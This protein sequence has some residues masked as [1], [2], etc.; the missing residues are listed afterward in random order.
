MNIAEYSIKYKVI[1]GLFLV[2]LTLGGISAF[3][4]LGRLE[5]P[6]FTLKDALIIATYPGA[7][8]QEV[9]EEL[10]YPLEREIRQ[11]PYI[12]NITSISSRGMSQL[13]S[14]IHI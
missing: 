10:T 13:L 12:D 2:L 8:P 6:A 4:G 5:D 1:S 7:T 3:N 11:L 14:L 9:E